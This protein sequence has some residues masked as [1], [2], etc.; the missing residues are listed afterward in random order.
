MT[1]LEQLGELCSKSVTDVSREC[2]ISM[3]ADK[4]AKRDMDYID[5]RTSMSD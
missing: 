2:C 1:E 5:I 3:S 4:L